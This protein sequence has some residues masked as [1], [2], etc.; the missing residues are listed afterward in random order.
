MP[1]VLGS[2]YSRDCDYPQTKGAGIMKHPNQYLV[3]AIK[4]IVMRGTEEIARATSSMKARLIAKA[5]NYYE[6]RAGGKA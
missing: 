4:N 1:C 5:L 2:R 6:Q 3:V